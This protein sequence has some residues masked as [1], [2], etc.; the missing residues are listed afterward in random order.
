M[1]DE[2]TN[3]SRQI[4]EELRRYFKAKLYETVIARNVRL[5]EAPSFGK[6]IQLY[7]IRSSGA[8]A[9]LSLAKE[10]TEK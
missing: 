10:M 4:E 3:L 8:R 5:S 7:D 1:Y 9:Y 6:P 2:R